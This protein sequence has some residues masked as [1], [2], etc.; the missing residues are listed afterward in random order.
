MLL[1]AKAFEFAQAGKSQTTMVS[2]KGHLPA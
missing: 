2:L 1:L